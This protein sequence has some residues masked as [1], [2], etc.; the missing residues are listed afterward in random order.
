MLLGIMVVS[1]C[2]LNGL[3]GR[4]GLVATS[5]LPRA[6]QFPLMEKNFF[7]IS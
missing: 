2:G 3:T 7:L 6:Y 4:P 1:P 5:E